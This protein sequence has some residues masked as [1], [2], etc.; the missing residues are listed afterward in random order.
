MTSANHLHYDCQGSGA[1]PK[2]ST[3]NRKQNLALVTIRKG[4]LFQVPHL[5][6]SLFSIQARA[7][8]GSVWLPENSLEFEM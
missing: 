1:V 3:V 2:S 6:S 5:Q 8:S 7:L 4:G